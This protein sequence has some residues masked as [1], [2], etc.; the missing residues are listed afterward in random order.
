MVR[1]LEIEKEIFEI[2]TTINRLVH[3]IELLSYVNP[4][5][6]EKERKHFFSSKYSVNPSFKYPKLDFNGYKLHRLLFTQKANG[7]QQFY[8]ARRPQNYENLQIRQVL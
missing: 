1:N 7:F 8:L 2:D 5:N 6:I 3:R 4:L